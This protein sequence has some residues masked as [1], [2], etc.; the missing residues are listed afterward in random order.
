MDS[1]CPRCSSRVDADPGVLVDVTLTRRA[2]PVFSDCTTLSQKDARFAPRAARASPRRHPPALHW[3]RPR[4]GMQPCRHPPSLAW[5]ACDTQLRERHLNHT[6]IEGQ[7]YDSQEA[8]PAIHAGAR[9]A[10]VPHRTFGNSRVLPGY[11]LRRVLDHVRDHLVDDLSVARLAAVA[12]MSS[13]HFS[14]LFKSSTG[15][16]PHRY[17]LLQRIECAKQRLANA[18][19]NVLAA[20]LDSGFENPSHFA[21][22]F[23]RFVGTSPSE[24]RADAL[25]RQYDEQFKCRCV[26]SRSPHVR[27]SVSRAS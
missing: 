9:P 3:S 5:C 2:S 6:I 10:A 27:V 4:G 15:V 1:E 12:A 11:R 13:H 26:E 24:Y 22:T 7:L 23:R 21:R 17:V 20:A 19:S 14:A 8:P 18:R 25:S 16:T